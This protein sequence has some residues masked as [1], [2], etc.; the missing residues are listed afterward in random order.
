MKDVK[1][2][3]CLSEQGHVAILAGNSR[4][5]MDVHGHIVV[6]PQL[7]A[8]RA[9]ISLAVQCN[10][11]GV[12]CRVSL[13]LDHKGIFRKQFLKDGLSN[14]AKRNPRLSQL[15]SEIVEV[16]APIMVGTGVPLE[17]V[18]IIHEDSARTH[19]SHLVQS[20]ECPSHL[21]RWMTVKPQNEDEDEDAGAGSCGIGT[22]NCS[23]GTRDVD[24]VTCA[25]VTAEYYAKALSADHHAQRL[26]VFIEN[27]PWSSIGVF[28]RGAALL[29]AMGS[30]VPLHL[31]LVQK[32]GR[33]IAPGRNGS[34]TLQ[35]DFD[36]RRTLLT[37]ERP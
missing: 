10:D 2:M 7:Q 33:V 11:A 34:A 18:F 8:F 24:R 20:G 1:N 31:N 22:G 35:H 14:S 27:D 25:A 32:D 23:Y 29:N 30:T 4:V 36:V 19:A 5:A 6:E 3:I 16:F 13:A 28:V 21:T 37:A 15:K 26:E 17:S 9:A 12:P